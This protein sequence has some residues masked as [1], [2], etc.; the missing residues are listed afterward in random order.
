MWNKIYI[1]H[2]LRKS[3]LDIIDALMKRSEVYVESKRYDF[4]VQPIEG[5]LLEDLEEHDR[6][7][8]SVSSEPAEDG[9]FGKFIRGWVNIRSSESP[10]IHPSYCA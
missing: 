2:P 3:G 4:V 7:F 1:Q 8:Y 6:F 5:D 10:A 9:T